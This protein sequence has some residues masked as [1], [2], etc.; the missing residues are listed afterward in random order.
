MLCAA[1]V[2]FEQLFDQSVK[3]V[4]SLRNMLEFYE[5]YKIF[6]LIH[7]G[8]LSFCVR[9]PNIKA[10][11]LSFVGCRKKQTCVELVNAC[12]GKYLKFICAATLTY[13]I[14]LCIFDKSL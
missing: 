14:Y 1:F 4:E 6:H 11:S 5:Q 7:V 3:I 2:V 10:C 9:E 8:T 13:F 12:N